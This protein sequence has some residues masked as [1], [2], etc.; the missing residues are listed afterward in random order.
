MIERQLTNIETR[1][2]GGETWATRSMS[3]PQ[4]LKFF[5]YTAIWPGLHLKE[6]T[7]MALQNIIDR[8]REGK[9]VD[10]ALQRLIKRGREAGLTVK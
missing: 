10:C 2:L 4:R 9:A 1:L 7:E 3:F 8:E 5:I 6:T